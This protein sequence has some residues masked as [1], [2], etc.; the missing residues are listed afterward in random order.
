M[1]DSMRSLREDVSPDLQVEA[2]C[3]NARSVCVPAKGKSALSASGHVAVIRVVR[4]FS[5]ESDLTIR[6]ASRSP[7]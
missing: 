2:G 5:F 7:G 1:I 3:I 4:P 6:T